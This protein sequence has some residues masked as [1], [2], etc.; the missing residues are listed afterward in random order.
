MVV[1]AAAVDGVEHVRVALAGAGDGAGEAPRGQED[2]S[3]HRHDRDRHHVGADQAIGETHACDHECHF[4]AGEGAP[5]ERHLVVSGACEAPGDELA[6]DEGAEADREERDR[7][8]SEEEVEVDL[9]GHGDHEDWDDDVLESLQQVLNAVFF[10][11]PLELP[12]VHLGEEHPAGVG[13][14]EGREAPPM[15]DPSEDDRRGECDLEAHGFPAVRSCHEARDGGSEDRACGQRG[16]EECDGLA[17]HDREGRAAAR[18]RH[19]AEE[20]GQDEEADDVVD[21]CDGHDELSRPRGEDLAL[22]EEDRRDAE[23]GRR[24]DRGREGTRHGAAPREDEGEHGVDDHA[25]HDHADRGHEA[26]STG[27]L[28]ERLEFGFQ[29]RFGQ[30][31]PD[32]ELRDGLNDVL[33]TVT[34]IAHEV[35]GHALQDGDVRQSDPEGEPPDHLRQACPLLDESADG[36][37]SGAQEDDGQKPDDHP[38][39][40]GRRLGRGVS[41]R[42]SYEERGEPDREER[43][44]F[45]QVFHGTTSLITIAVSG[46]IPAE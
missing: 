16:D 18:A 40:E 3:H 26:A 28:H 23:A 27:I 25:G 11:R 22:F 9:H 10:L 33:D 34:R 31:D 1:A 12:E 15:G 8:R 20:P 44:Q 7:A 14:H 30:Q 35:V 42:H 43:A 39:L 5:G 36:L 37:G 45:L 6:Q 24:E 29:T 4:A 19:H 17:Q 32:A 21:G 46:R 41:D 38:V 2:A 13:A